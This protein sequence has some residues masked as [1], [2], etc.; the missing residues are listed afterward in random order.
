MAPVLLG[1]ERERAH[2]ELQ[3]LQVQDWLLLEE[4]AELVPVEALRVGQSVVAELEPVRP[5]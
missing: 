2:R 4:L 5:E 1:R 3:V